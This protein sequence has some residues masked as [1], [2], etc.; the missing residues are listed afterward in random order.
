[1]LPSACMTRPLKI[2]SVEGEL[3]SARRRRCGRPR[4]L[5]NAVTLALWGGDLI[6]RA[7]YGPRGRFSYTPALA[8]QLY[9]QLSVGVEQR[10]GWPNLPLPVGLALLLGERV[11]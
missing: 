4:R 9:A 3:I 1:M 8:L 6:R 10:V 2:R 11:M 7:I 5:V